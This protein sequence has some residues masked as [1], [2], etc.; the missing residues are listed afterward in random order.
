MVSGEGLE[1]TRVISFIGRHCEDDSSPEGFFGRQTDTK[2]DRRKSRERGLSRNAYADE[3]AIGSYSTTSIV[4]RR[5]A[6]QKENQVV[7]PC[8]LPMWRITNDLISVVADLAKTVGPKTQRRLLSHDC[9]P[10]VQKLEQISGVY[11]PVS[12]FSA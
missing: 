2:K 7:P 1:V 4:L 8:D 6:P 11:D 3:E 12:R 9:D 5:V 10:Y